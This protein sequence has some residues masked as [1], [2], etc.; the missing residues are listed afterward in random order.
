MN[1]RRLVWPAA[2]AGSG[3]VLVGV[4]IYLA[5]TL[6]RVPAVVV[7]HPGPQAGLPQQ[8]AAGL[9][10]RLLAISPYARNHAAPPRPAQARRGLWIE[11]PEV[12]IDLPVRPG[13]GSDNIPDWTALVYPGTAAPG[14]PGNSYIYAHGIWGMFGGLLLTRAGDHLYLR[15]YTTGHVADFVV[16]RVVGRVAYDDVRWLDATSATPLLTLQTCIG[17]DVKGD[18]FI[19]LATPAGGSTE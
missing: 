1:D 15:D 13:D 6:A 12:G 11:M 3:M 4:G 14:G 8:V 17:W 9:S 2:V 18:R 10:S 5:L 19:V 16:S 7:D